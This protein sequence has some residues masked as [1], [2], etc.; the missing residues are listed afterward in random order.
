MK[1]RGNRP[2]SPHRRALIG[3]AGALAATAALAACSRAEAPVDDDGRVRLRFATDWRAQAEHGGFYQALASGA[4]EKRGLN[5]QIIQ[6]GPAVNVPQLLASG[7]VELGMGSNSFIP[8]NLVEEGAPVKAVAAFFQKD[9]QVLIAH[10]DPALEGIADLRGRPF[11]LATAAREAFWVWLKAKYGFTDDQVRTYTF[12]L[13]PFLSDPRAVQQGYLT[14]EPYTI[15]KEAGFTPKVFLLAD[16]GYPSYATMVLAPTAFARDN[17]RALRGFIAASAEGW[18]DYIQGDGRAADA[19]IR[20]DNPDMTQDVLDQARAKLKA[21]GI[22][23]GGDA[24]LYGLGAMTAER[25]R[26]FFEVTSAAGLY[27]PGLDWREAFTT[28][29]LPGRG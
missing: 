21:H 23:D 2:T 18:R 8:M 17:A 28:Q 26:T 15:E 24:A 10:P 5:V 13:A 7:A 27:P 20:R 29:Y 22:V 6:G 16:E 14:S 1:L 3:G 19:L 25:W 9:P 4:Y 11:L 12:N